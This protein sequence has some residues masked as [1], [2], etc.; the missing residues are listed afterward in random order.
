M[1]FLFL[2]FLGLV[3]GLWLA[4][5]GIVIPNNWKCFKDIFEKSSKELISL[6]VALAVFPNYI[7]KGYKITNNPKIRVLFDACFC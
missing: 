5:P 3:L 2:I 1:K 6:K 7:L 4:W